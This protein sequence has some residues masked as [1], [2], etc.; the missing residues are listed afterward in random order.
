M[1]E[2]TTATS[3]VIDRVPCTNTSIYPTLITHILVNLKA[4]KT[5]AVFACDAILKAYMRI[6]EETVISPRE[7]LGAPIQVIIRWYLG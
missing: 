6:K 3:H 7:W 1:N 4:P 5:S 2:W